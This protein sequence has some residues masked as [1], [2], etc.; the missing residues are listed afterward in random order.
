MTV[1]NFEWLQQSESKPTSERGRID[2]GDESDE[3][4]QR[5]AEYLKISQTIRQ[6]KMTLRLNGQLSDNPHPLEEEEALLN[7]AKSIGRKGIA[8]WN[9][10]KA[11][12]P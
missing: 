12:R 3:E 10:F 9:K 2:D 5:V 6:W 7:H 1:S 4:L 11:F 8:L